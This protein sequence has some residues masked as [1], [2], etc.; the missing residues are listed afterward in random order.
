MCSYT[1]WTIFKESNNNFRCR[2]WS[3]ELNCSGWIRY[4]ILSVCS[5]VPVLSPPL[6]LMTN[7]LFLDDLMDTLCKWK[8]YW[9]GLL[10]FTRGE[11]IPFR[12]KDWCL[13]HRGKKQWQ[14]GKGQVDA[15]QEQGGV[16]SPACST[17]QCCCVTSHPSVCSALFPVGVRNQ[18]YLYWGLAVMIWGQRNLTFQSTIGVVSL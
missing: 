13:H 8:Y 3:V 15:E 6:S 2:N 12:K 9:T 11:G 4:G 7:L 16:A 14:C 17:L 10:D 5:H 18:L 1:R